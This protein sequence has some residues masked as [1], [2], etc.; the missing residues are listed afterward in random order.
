MES[1]N[2][3]IKVMYLNIIPPQTVIGT[4]LFYDETECDY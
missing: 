3:V 2:D 1:S 4:G